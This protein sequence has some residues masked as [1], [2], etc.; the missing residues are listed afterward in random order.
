MSWTSKLSK[1]A[2][3]E[4]RHLPRDRQQQLSQAIEEMREDPLRGDV[5]PIKIGKFKGALRKRV[6]RY[7]TIFALDPSEHLIRIAAILIRTEKTYR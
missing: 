3:K 1:E 7:R 6:G 2:A 4:F 5:R